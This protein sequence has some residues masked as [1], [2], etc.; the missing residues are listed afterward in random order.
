MP[1]RDPETSSFEKELLFKGRTFYSPEDPERALDLKPQI[2]SSLR[3]PNNGARALPD[4]LVL[5]TREAQLGPICPRLSAA[6]RR[7]RAVSC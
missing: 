7:M 6:R 5:E 2:P 3:T 4:I 1:P